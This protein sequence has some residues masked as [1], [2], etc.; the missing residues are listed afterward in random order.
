KCTSGGSNGPK[1]LWIGPDQSFLVPRFSRPLSSDIA[2]PF[3]YVATATSRNL[4][5]HLL[6][7]VIFASGACSTSL[8]T[9]IYSRKAQ[10]YLL[11]T[12]RISLQN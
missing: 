8:R 9:W 2:L 7:R 4:D 3:G 1:S 12:V 5:R 11:C 10:S 6:I